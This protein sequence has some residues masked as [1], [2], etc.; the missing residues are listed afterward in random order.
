MTVIRNKVEW[1]RWCDFARALGFPLDVAAK[2]YKAT[3]TNEQNA[4][5][6]SCCYPPL[7]ER[8]G[9]TAEE[10]HEYVLGKHFGWVDRR[11]PKTPRNP[12]GIASV[13]RRTTTADED[14]KRSVLDKK[15]FSDFVDTVHRVA[16]EAGVFIPD[17]APKEE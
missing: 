7:V 10:I 1:D 2:P 4:Y 15:D 13:P 3:R 9:Y 11:V 12:G 6:W 8:T 17:P 14:G 16:A 5:L